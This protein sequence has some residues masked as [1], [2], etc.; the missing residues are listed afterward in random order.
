MGRSAWEAEVEWLFEPFQDHTGDIWSAHLKN[1]TY[2]SM[3]AL[4]EREQINTFI[5]NQ[6]RFCFAN[7]FINSKQKH[8]LQLLYIWHINDYFVSYLKKS[9]EGFRGH[10]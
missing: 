8:L 6:L 9:I 4:M 3:I 10:V 7:G 5:V 1:K 2:N